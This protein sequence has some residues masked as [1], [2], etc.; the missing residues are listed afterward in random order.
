MDENETPKQSN[1][2]SIFGRRWT[3]TDAIVVAIFGL[4][5]GL[6]GNWI[7]LLTKDHELKIK[8]VEIGIGILRADPKENLT[9]AREWAIRIIETNSG[10][11][12]SE[13]DKGL[14][15]KKP[16]LYDFSPDLGTYGSGTLD[17]PTYGKGTR[18]SPTAPK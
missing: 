15:L 1:S 11:K 12:F 4:L 3:V 13:N 2:F 6:I 18:D 10:L 17:S 5:T 14:L 8:L 16:I 7:G 9:P